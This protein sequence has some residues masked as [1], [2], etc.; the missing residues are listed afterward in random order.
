MR[1]T[2]TL[3]LI[4]EYLADRKHAGLSAASIKL[5]VVA[6]RFFSGFCR[7]RRRE[8]RSDRGA[9]PCRELSVIC[10]RR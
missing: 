1:A 10:R 6:L 4:S 8:T 9:V 3:P 2:V 5:I 7:A